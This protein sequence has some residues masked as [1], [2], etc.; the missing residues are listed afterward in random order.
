M[1]DTPADQLAQLRD[2]EIQLM[3][4]LLAVLAPLPDVM[5]RDVYIEEEEEDEDFIFESLIEEKSEEGNFFTQEFSFS[6][7]ILYS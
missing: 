7:R 4:Q 3:S 5:E 1:I 2:E 6:Y